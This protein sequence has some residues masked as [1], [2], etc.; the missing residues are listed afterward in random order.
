MFQHVVKM[1]ASKRLCTDK[2]NFR[3]VAIKQTEVTCT[4]FILKAFSYLELA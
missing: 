3:G 2:E 1:L 4:V